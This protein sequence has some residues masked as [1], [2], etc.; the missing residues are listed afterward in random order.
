[1][2]GAP[3]PLSIR[4]KH[5]NGKEGQIVYEVWV[6]AITDSDVPVLGLCLRIRTRGPFLVSSV[7]PAPFCKAVLFNGQ[8]LVEAEPGLISIDQT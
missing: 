3:E 8:I 2:P 4:H 5:S 7:K 1:M 6:V